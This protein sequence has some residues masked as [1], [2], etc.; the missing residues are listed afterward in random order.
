M[1]GPSQSVNV[2]PEGWMG[3]GMGRRESL[4]PWTSEPQRQMDRVTLSRRERAGRQ[5]TL[6]RHCVAG[7]G[8]PAPHLEL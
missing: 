2:G 4:Q 8:A 7:M 5:V 6:G 3:L 1:E